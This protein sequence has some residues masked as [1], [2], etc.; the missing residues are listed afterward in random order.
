MDWRLT[1][2]FIFILTFV[3]LLMQMGFAQPVDP[4]RPYIQ[5]FDYK[6]YAA[7]Q[8]NWSIV[9]DRRGVIYV[10]NNWGILEYDGASW[11]LITTEKNVAALSLDIDSSGT[12]WVGLESEMGYLTPDSAGNT[13]FVSIKSHLPEEEQDFSQVWKVHAT[14]EGI[15]F[16]TIKKLLL[17]DGKTLRSNPVVISSLSTKARD[18]MY[19]VEYEKGIVQ[20]ED[21]K[22]HIVPGTES[23]KNEENQILLPYG[24]VDSL[25]IVTKNSG[26][27]L[28]DGLQV[29]PFNTP[30]NDWLKQNFPYS[31]LRTIS[32]EYVIGT[33][34]GGA[35]V[36]DKNGERLMV[37]DRNAGLRDQT[38]VSVTEDQEGSIWLAL[39]NGLARF[40][41]QTPFKRYDAANGIESAVFD[42]KRHKGIV[43]AGTQLGAFYLDAEAENSEEGLSKAF[44]PISE[45]S[46]YT[47]ILQEE[48][49]ILL[50]GTDRGVYEID[51]ANAKR[52]EARWP[53][54]YDFHR[55]V[56]NP[57]RVY[58][59]L[60]NGLSI[61]LKE[62]GHWE[63]YRRVQQLDEE[64]IAIAGDEN[65]LLWLGTPSSGVLQ[66][67]VEPPSEAN[68]NFYVARHKRYGEEHGLPSGRIEPENLPGRIVFSTA[69]GI[70]SFDAKL[71]SFMLAEGFFQGS[72]SSGAIADIASG[73][74]GTTWITANSPSGIIIAAI[75]KDGAVQNKT[76]LQ[77]LADLGQIQT[78]YPEALG[79]GVWFGGAE[80][81][82]RFSGEE[83]AAGESEFS[84]LIRGVLINGDSL[85]YSGN[86]VAELSPL[87]YQ[88]NALRFE[89]SATSFFDPTQLQFRYMLE[90]FDPDWSA[91]NR[92]TRKDY[93]NL[94][95]GDYVFR[96]EGKNL[97][98]K[99]EQNAGFSFSILPPWY[100][101][102]WAYLLYGLAAIAGI[103]MLTRLQTNRY[104]AKAREALLR[105]KERARLQE[106]TLRAENAEAQKEVE[107][108]Q[109]RSRIASDLHDEIGSNLSSISV[110]SQMLQKRDT[111]GEKELDRLEN[112]QQ[113]SQQTANSMRDIVW[114]VNPVNDR[115]DRLFA[116][117]RDTANTMLEQIEFHFSL[118]DYDWAQETDLNFRRNLFLI[119]KESLQNI[120]KH[121]RASRAEINISQ[122]DGVFH[123]SIADDGVGFNPNEKHN[124][125]GLNNF[126]TRAREIGA[127]LSISSKP[128]SGTTLL[129]KIPI[130]TF[131]TAKIP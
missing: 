43:Y 31:A 119:Y 2:R 79:K 26:L 35:L 107:K 36:M 24:S 87:S 120:V 50:A 16:L 52:V 51:G 70:Y 113:I 37:L 101:S 109:I 4:G 21:C 125:N 85:A 83:V 65:D 58:V 28:Y 82:A 93:T 122:E 49:G 60:L 8:E 12:V 81:I 80:G 88:N 25:L 127:D 1:N 20:V 116:K 97:Y 118:Q 123:L 40:E 117:M 75:G 99:T 111:I 44:K 102:W 126:Q 54:V 78:V 41:P 64:I 45:I 6:T 108:E 29:A 7:H 56:K 68:E 19:F 124:G 59:A 33:I 74:E 77:R 62:K 13:Q 121:A 38:I 57:E 32:G 91:W 94:P 115:L 9:Q 90:G 18:V 10:G 15:Y 103:M 131:L 23:I 67:T 89:Y 30:V 114:F 130:S 98:G 17:W 63:H 61:M 22:T 86:G 27:F 129:L 76:A 100:R 39:T 48:D 106:A 47:Y 46:T 66:V 92:E 112:I 73:A 14:P 53:R 105:E 96:V 104:R 95:E 128:G 5:N 69:E 71:D 55:G 3:A 84:T 110:I 34:R 11:R 72:H 42:I